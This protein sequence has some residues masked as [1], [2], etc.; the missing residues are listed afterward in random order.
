MTRMGGARI[1]MTAKNK[2]YESWRKRLRLFRWREAEMPDSQIGLLMYYV[3]YYC[4][5]V[6]TAALPTPFYQH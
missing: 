4:T 5:A 2:K 1:K 6:T 3:S